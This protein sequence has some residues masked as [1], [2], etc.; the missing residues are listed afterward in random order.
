MPGGKCLSI[1]S[2]LSDLGWGRRHA[3]DV[4]DQVRRRRIAVDH[5]CPAVQC[6]KV[7]IEPSLEPIDR[8]ALEPFQARRSEPLIEAILTFDQE[9]EAALSVVDIESE[10]K[11]HPF[12]IDARRCGGL[13]LQQL[14]VRRNVSRAG[15]DCPGVDAFCDCAREWRI[16]TYAADIHDQMT[17]E[18]AD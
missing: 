16:G 4:F 2:D 13:R 18:I 5:I 6:F 12:C 14:T 10:E 8:L 9:S 17:D 11:G 1:G 3:E 7:I 15:L